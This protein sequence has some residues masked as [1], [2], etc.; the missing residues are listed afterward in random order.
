MLSQSTIAES[1]LMHHFVVVVFDVA[2]FQN[3]PNKIRNRISNSSYNTFSGGAEHVVFKS[4]PF[5][6]YTVEP[7]FRIP[8]HFLHLLCKCMGGSLNVPNENL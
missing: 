3:R 8:Y 2:Q 5:S 4:Y 1:L 7:S 6:P